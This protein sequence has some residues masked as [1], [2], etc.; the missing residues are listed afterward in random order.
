MGDRELTHEDPGP[1]YLFRQSVAQC[2]G[3]VPHLL[4]P[5]LVF[6]GREEGRGT[7][8]I[9]DR[10]ALALGALPPIGIGAAVLCCH[11]CDGRH[12]RQGGQEEVAAHFLCP[13]VARGRE[14]ARG[15]RRRVTEWLGDWVIE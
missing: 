6:H 5:T 4:S 7:E 10:A 9:V 12:G 2:C 8:P 1:E 13:V 14:K 3:V 11:A 15:G